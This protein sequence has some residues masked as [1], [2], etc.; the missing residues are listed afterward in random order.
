MLKLK[1]YSSALLSLG[2]FL[3]MAMG[4][5]FIFIRPALLPED[6]RYIN[7]NLKTLEN[8]IPNLQPWLQK[9]FC[10]MGGYIFATG[11]LVIFISQTSFRA[12]TPGS[13]AIVIIAGVSS[14]GLMVGVNFLIDSDFKW[15]LLVFILPWAI[16]LTLYR[17]HK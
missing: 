9:V 1:P 11:L 2:G 13:F 17:Y 15:M 10:V 6:F 14:I 8:E 5:Y 4:L 3:F 16:S 7:I 12:R